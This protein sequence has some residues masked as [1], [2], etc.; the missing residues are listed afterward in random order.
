MSAAAGSAAAPSS[1]SGQDRN[2]EATVYVGNLDD[3][4]TESLL[5]ELM[6]QVGPIT[7]VNIPKDRITMVHQGY[8]FVEFQSEEDAEY[9]V[10]VMNL[11]RLYGKPIRVNKASANKKDYDIGATLFIG[12]LSPDV[13]ERILFEAFSSFGKI[14]N[15]PRVQR[16]GVTG[17]SKGYG[18]VSFDN[19][20][21]ADLA[22]ESMNGQFLCGRS[23]SVSYA[24]K[25]EGRGEKHGTCS[26]RLLASEAKRHGMLPSQNPQAADLGAAAQ[27]SISVPSGMYLLPQ[28]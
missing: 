23:I 14:L 24:L 5:Y 4:V 20:E 12:N 2:Q 26:E 28:Q 25:K 8:G 18:F 11:I 19:F 16:D 13:D 21:T 27:P 17:L 6:L 7:H 22:I 1:F 9:C 10:K 3:K 15:T